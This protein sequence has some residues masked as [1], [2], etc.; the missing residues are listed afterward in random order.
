MPILN[1]NQ[2]AD[3]VTRKL[4]KVISPDLHRVADYAMIGGFAGAGILYWKRNRRAAIA[5]LLCGGS[6]LALA[7][8][9]RYDGER[10][11]RMSFA[12]HHRTE[13][14]MAAAFALLPRLLR[15]GKVA[16]AHFVIQSVALTAFTNLTEFGPP[17]TE[18]IR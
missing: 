17:D 8:A 15:I 9:T 12:E 18:S 2:T 1:L 16:K 14:G 11:G 13:L 5:S 10:S 4:P 6:M 3:L 7:L